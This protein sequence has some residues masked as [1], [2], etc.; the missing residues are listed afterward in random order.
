M[1]VKTNTPALQQAGTS[2]TMELENT[3]S[4]ADSNKQNRIFTVTPNAFEVKARSEAEAY[5]FARKLISQQG[6]GI[7]TIEEE[8]DQ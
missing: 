1:K 4:D 7:D 5:E 8:S 3:R 6:V 2:I